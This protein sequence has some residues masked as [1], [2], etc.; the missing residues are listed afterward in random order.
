MKA[1][2][3]LMT[4]WMQD[5][6]P[7]ENGYHVYS[8]Q[9]ITS[10]RNNVIK[11]ES[12]QCVQNYLTSTNVRSL[13][14][15]RL[16]DQ[17]LEKQV[18]E[19]R[20]LTT[21]SHPDLRNELLKASQLI[22]ENCMTTMP[23]CARHFIEMVIILTEDE[24]EQISKKST[25]LLSNTSAI[26]LSPD[27]SV[28][29]VYMIR[30][31]DQC[32]ENL[33]RIFSGI[34]EDKKLASV[35]LLIGYISLFGSYKLTYVLLS[36]QNLNIVLQRLF[37]VSELVK[38]RVAYKF[39][40]DP[41]RQILDNGAASIWK[42]FVNFRDDRVQE[43]VEKLCR[44]LAR[45]TYFRMVVDALLDKIQNNIADK[46]EAI[47]VLNAS[48]SGCND[49]TDE[50][51][52]N[53]VVLTYVDPRQLDVPLEVSE[54]QGC[55][56]EEMHRNI[57]QVCILLDGIG[58]IASKLGRRFQYH[59][60]RALYLV[61]EKAGNQHPFVCFS[62]RL[63]LKRICKACGY[64]SIKEMI[65]SSIDFISF[66]VKN[67]LRRL[68]DKEKVLQVVTIILKTTTLDALPIISN[69]MEFTVKS[70]DADTSKAT[71][72]LV[73]FN[74]FILTLRE[75]VGIERKFEPIK[76]REQRYQEM[77]EFTV[78]GIEEDFSDNLDEMSAEE[79]FRQDLQKKE[80]ELINEIEKPEVEEYK[81]PEPPVH[82]ILTVNILR[83]ALYFLP[84]KNP[85]QRMK[86]FEVILNGIEILEHWEDELLPMVHEIWSPL[87][88]R[89][90]E[91]DDPLTINYSFKLLTILGRLS[92]EFIRMRTTKEVLP[93]ILQLLETQ[94][95]SSMNISSSSYMYSQVLKLQLRVLK[96]IG[97]L[98]VHLDVEKSH[99]EE[100]VDK[101]LI[102]MRNKQPTNLQEAAMESIDSLMT[103]DKSAVIPRLT[104]WQ[105]HVGFSKRVSSLLD[106]HEPSNS[107]VS[108]A[109]QSISS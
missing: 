20:K 92:K 14:W 31:F 22:L 41:S 18:K 72:F 25:A 11:F 85:E 93:H 28:I 40:P 39:L 87:V 63:A 9:P 79:M 2:G 58:I 7:S 94:S 13:E 90:K 101:L 37:V 108:D 30:G 109:V 36:D 97:R 33:P 1:W 24:D 19:F 38:Y 57:T 42:Q 32:I 91:I 54:M 105:R 26:L 100:V 71:M 16:N 56:L 74:E 81:K 68:E 103:Y 83:R 75:W 17:N 73:V 89:F 4:L 80:E 46:L 50:D 65:S 23:K 51:A 95:N 49:T 69:M 21:R 98:M 52:L 5:Y 59:L 84:S 86:A 96:D 106:C 34:D 12:Q 44:L 76:S 8:N 35:N 47:F 27:F 53:T 60:P 10:G 82:V 29:V 104:F 55:S 6:S 77:Q 45:G 43:K 48:I 78:S 66:H 70:L 15:Y 88:E 67:R 64:T 61:F 102:Y 3:R 62:G 107:P 99:I